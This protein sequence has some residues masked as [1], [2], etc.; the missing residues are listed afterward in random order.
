[1]LDLKTD[2]PIKEELVKEVQ[3]KFAQAKDIMDEALNLL[4]ISVTKEKAKEILLT[5]E[6]VA[7]KLRCKTNE[8]PRSVPRFKSG[9][10]WL[11]PSKDLDEWIKERIKR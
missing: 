8:I 5:R 2:M 10:Q 7:E 9:K 3:V 11:F 4:Q 1:M 6:E